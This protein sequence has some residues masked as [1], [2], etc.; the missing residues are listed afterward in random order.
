MS[1]GRPNSNNVLDGELNALRRFLR[2]LLTLGFICSI[3]S[4]TPSYYM[5]EVYDR[6]VNSRDEL[7]LLMLTLLTLGLYVLMEALNWVREQ[8]MHHAALG[9]DERLGSRIFN[10]VFEAGL[11]TGRSQLHVLRDFR[12]FSDFL[13]SRAL[14][15]VLDAPFSLLY[16]LLVFLMH[17]ALGAATVV[18]LIVQVWLTYRSELKTQKPLTEANRAGIAAQTYVG[19]TLRNAQVIE[20]MGMIQ[21][22]Y[23]RWTK[24]QNELLA[25]QAEASDHAGSNSAA[26]KFLQ[27]TLS[28]GL[29][30]LSVVFALEG[31]LN[32]GSG[33]MIIASIMG[34]KALAPLVQLVTQWK[35]IVNARDAYGRL[36]QLIVAFPAREEG[37]PLPRP[38][39]HLS[40]EALVAGAPGSQIPILKGVNFAI[41]AGESLAVVGP[42][43]SGKTTLARLLI[44][45]WP[46][47]SGKVRLDGADVFTWNK[48]ELGPAIG[49]L[50]Q[51][52]ELF[53]G[54]LAENIARFGEVDLAKVQEAVNLV[55]LNELVDNLPDGLNTVI[56]EEGGFLSGG[57][58]QRVALA[59]AI[60]GNP[61]F[62]VL[63]EPNASLDQAGEAA[64]QQTLAVLKA[65]G[66]TLILITHRTNILGIADKMLVLHDGLVKMFGPRDDVL[67]ALAGNANKQP[68]APAA[69]PVPARA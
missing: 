16:L 47:I 32:G 45:V 51:G 1:Q 38:E 49:Y 66:T 7:T 53:D 23:Q 14:Q 28:S 33:M 5:L 43:A 48:E 57:Q 15:A 29:L 22:I 61:S 56:G 25:K 44:G 37:M 17:P 52:V 69:A 54:T 55:G 27:Q 46:A 26:S 18:A 9:F 34:G 20:A 65:R 12:T 67:A 11:R 2:K 3:L 19:N 42:S 60:Y 21:P 35:A 24:H 62:V 41:Q 40:V 64:L 59:R 50:P 39:G 58:R 4:L 8:I 10:A 30:A 36:K 13:G 31:T 6:V 68:A 63:D